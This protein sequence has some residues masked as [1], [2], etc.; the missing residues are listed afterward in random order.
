M[1]SEAIDLLKVHLS[2]LNP[3]TGEVGLA[4]PGLPAKVYHGP[5]CPGISNSRLGT[6]KSY[7]DFILGFKGKD[8]TPEMNF[9]SAVHDA[10]LLPEVFENEYIVQPKFGLKKAEKEAK[11]IWLQENQGKNFLEQEDFDNVLFIRDK[12]WKI[13]LARGLLSGGRPELSLFWVN[14]EGEVCKARLDYLRDDGIVIDLKTTSNPLRAAFARSI[15]YFNYDRQAAW[16][17]EGV[18]RIFGGQN[19]NFIFIAIGNKKPFNIRFYP[20]GKRSIETGKKLYAAALQRYRYFRNLSLQQFD[21]DSAESVLQTIDVPHWA[22]K[23]E[24]RD[25]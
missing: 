11:K 21:H 1:S 18:N 24:L 9:G 3:M 15:A 12:L 16:Y 13:P 4:M 19:E 20:L 23:L 22:H 7:E 25:A 5:D 6:T 17:L 10:C 14:D 8:P 2:Q